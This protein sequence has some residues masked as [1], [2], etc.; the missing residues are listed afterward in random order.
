LNS[1]EAVS[2]RLGQKIESQDKEI[3]DLLKRQSEANVN[4]QDQLEEATSAIKV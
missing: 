2:K 4:T 1:V 3:K